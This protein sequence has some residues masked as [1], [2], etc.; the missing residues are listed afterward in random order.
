MPSSQRA[1]YYHIPFLIF[2]S[3]IFSLVSAAHSQDG[4]RVKVE[5]GTLEGTWEHGLEVFRGI[6]YAAPPI[7]ELRWRTPRKPLP[8]QSIREAT[9]FGPACPQPPSKDIPESGMSEDCLTLN[10]WSP[11]ER[12]DDRMPVM[13]W[14]HGGSFKNGSA[15]IGLYDGA[16]LAR[17]GV[18]IVSIN[19]RLGEFGFFGH[20]QLTEEARAEHAPTANF[21][22]LDQIEALKWVRR[23]I[24]AFGG[25]PLNV[26]LFGESAGGISVLA[27]MTS[28]LAKELFQKAI[29]QS[30]GGRWIAP[31]LTAPGGGRLSAHDYGL[32]AQQALDIK[33]ENA[34]HELRAKSW[35]EIRDTLD[36]IPE[37]KDHSP[38]IDGEVLV[39]QIEPIFARGEQARV[40][41]IVGANT[42]EGVFLRGDF[43]VSNAKVFN[44]VKD[45][46]DA[47]T[48]LYPAQGWVNDDRLADYIWGDANFVEPA[49]MIA[50]YASRSGQAVYHYSFDFLPPLFR[51]FIGGSPH[52]LDVVY[53]FGNFDRV[54]PFPLVFVM[55]PDNRHISEI[56][57]ASWTSFAKTGDPNVGGLVSWP[58]FRMGNEET[59]VFGNDGPSV[60]QDHLKERLDAFHGAIW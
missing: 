56:M 35:Q 57:R 37:L 60:E 1:I 36:A 28:P 14:I 33:N 21:G 15:R 20:P 54:V 53:V 38:F 59:Y 48:E 27:L 39:D 19:Y 34:L 45:Q 32:K 4:P 5:G 7:G 46:F 58:R 55:H 51:M 26:T 41:L 23:N 16:R 2:V 13:V 25:D 6:P 47:L 8:W 17:E 11:E 44:A 42:Y 29:A 3:A 50:R 30:G 31:A 43:G 12:P 24:A 49:R 52:G 40:P 10:I 18:V 22:L 9:D